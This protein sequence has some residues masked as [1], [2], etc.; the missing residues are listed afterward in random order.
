MVRA[1]GADE[2]VPQA[3]AHLPWGHVRTILDKAATAKGRV[4]IVCRGGRPVWLVPERASKHDHEPF[5][6]APVLQAGRLACLIHNLFVKRL[7]WNGN[8]RCVLSLGQ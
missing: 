7:L 1:W 2:N 8:R 5:D 6:G 4:G 3:V